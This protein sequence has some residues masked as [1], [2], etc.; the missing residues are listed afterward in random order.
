[1][2]TLSTSTPTSARTLKPVNLGLQ[3][4]L[5]LAVLALAFAPL[6]AGRAELRLLMEV[7]SYLALAQMW[8]L[9]AGYSGL[10]SVGQQAYV[11][12]GGYLFFALA[13]FA[14]IPV[15][16]AL[17]LAAVVTALI[18]IPS[19]WVAFR[20][21]GAYFAIGTWVIAEVFRLT[22]AQVSALGGGSGI[23]LPVALA[24]SIA[25]SRDGR[26][27]V[28]YYIAFAVDIASVVLVWGLLRSKWGLALTAIRDSEPAAEAVGVAT[29]RVKFLI[30]VLTALF[31]GLTGAFIFLQKLRIT[32]DAA[33]S[34]NDWTA[35]VI[36]IVVIGG[37]GT[38]E[39]PIVGV[40]VFFVLREIAADWGSWYL[41]MMGAIAIAVMLVDKRGIWGA[42]RTRYGLS[43]LPVGHVLDLSSPAKPD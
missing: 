35:F 10:I 1:M 4:A 3:L 22:A 31:T 11:G 21:Q 16:A 40:I 18:A 34:I 30:Y 27:T 20:L 39:G 15:L 17:P 13:M 26:E 5:A 33:F 19:G 37:L 32:P 24:K 41:I 42:L 28:M 7:L 2:S 6:W 38:I 25:E 8:N 29:R 23:S 36:F 43:I 14:G 9:L 12:L